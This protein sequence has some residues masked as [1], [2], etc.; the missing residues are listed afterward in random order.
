MKKDYFV[1]I[2]GAILLNVLLFTS[3]NQAQNDSR[4]NGWYNIQDNKKDSISIEP[5]VTV[6]DFVALK[7]DSIEIDGKPFYEIDGKISKHKLIKWNDATKKAI[8]KRIGFVYNNEVVNCPQINMRLES[9]NFSI[10]N[11][12]YDIRK[13]FYNIRQ[14]KVDS[15]ESLFQD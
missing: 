15:I 7:L 9:A 6:K 2:L 5:I 1:I 13:L 12:A 4:E 14:E 3:C 8:G 11:R 10:S